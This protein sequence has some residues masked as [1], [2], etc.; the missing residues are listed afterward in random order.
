MYN[1]QVHIYRTFRAIKLI[2]EGYIYTVVSLK[3]GLHTGMSYDPIFK[4]NLLN[5]NIRG[6]PVKIRHFFASDN[7]LFKTI[8]SVCVEY[9][10]NRTEIALHTL[11][12]YHITTCYL[13]MV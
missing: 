3:F 8:T 1:I 13:H 12:V 2:E 7:F 9:V 6:K 11:H 10:E 4:I 5:A